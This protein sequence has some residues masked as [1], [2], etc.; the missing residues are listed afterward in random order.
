MHS[1]AEL[2]QQA[3]GIQRELRKA[4]MALKQKDTAEMINAGCDAAGAQRPDI[5]AINENQ[6]VAVWIVDK[7]ID[8]KTQEWAQ[9]NITN[10]AH[11]LLCGSDQLIGGRTFQKNAKNIGGADL[12]PD[13]DSLAGMFKLALKNGK[14]PAAK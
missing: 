7:A 4:Q 10:E 14:L 11:Q 13:A 3:R 6:I 5:A 12:T 8:G 2:K 1:A 9:L